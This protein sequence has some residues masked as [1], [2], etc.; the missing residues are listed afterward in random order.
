MTWRCCRRETRRGCWGPE[1]VAISGIWSPHHRY[2]DTREWIASFGFKHIYPVAAVFWALGDGI[3]AHYQLGA[4][5]EYA[6]LR[7]R[8]EE[9]LDL[10]GDDE[11][12]RQLSQNLEWRVSL[13]P[14]LIPR[15][16]LRHIYLD[17]RMFSLAKDATLVD[18]GAFDGDSLRSFLLWQGMEFDCYHAL[19]PDPISFG[20]L[21]AYVAALPEGLRQKTIPAR[22][23]A[24]A[25]KG[26]I[27]FS[28]S[29][30][31]GS[32]VGASGAQS[33]ETECVRLCDFFS[34]S[35]VDYLKFDI[36]GAEWDAL[37]GRMADRARASDTRLPLLLPIA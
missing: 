29:G 27:A 1:A 13:D 26:S 19:E 34:D 17:P 33:V 8:A 7:Q 3:G 22:V 25:H 21:E 9:L 28:M 31:P 30:K 36:E 16:D 18:V 24:G 10:L 2:A 35:R 11:S 15:P 20:N 6:S 37:Q 5:G 14:S 4:P 12:R 32:S 23:A